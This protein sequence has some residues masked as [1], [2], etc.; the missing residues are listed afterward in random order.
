MIQNR[1]NACVVGLLCMILAL[2]LGGVGNVVLCLGHDGHIALE[3]VGDLHCT[4][5]TVLAGIQSHECDLPVLVT[6]DCH[7]IVLSSHV[8]PAKPE[9][10]SRGKR[11]VPTPRSVL[12]PYT[13]VS[14]LDV[15]SARRAR[16]LTP[17]FSSHLRSLRTVV[18]LV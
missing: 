6:R 14:A 17:V 7:D 1:G 13:S 2:P 12:S 18:L 8:P 10:A 16:P 3:P 5:E 11:P 4:N 15:C 9:G